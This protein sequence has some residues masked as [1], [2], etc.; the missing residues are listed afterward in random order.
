MQQP[1]APYQYLISFLWSLFEATFFFIIPDVWLSFASLESLKNGFKNIGFA[2]LGAL[3]GGSIMY[4]LGSYTI[5]NVATFLEFIPDIN[6]NRLLE[7]EEILKNEGLTAIF[8][9][10]IKGIPYKIYAS[11][12]GVLALNFPL[13]ILISIPARAMRFIITVV[14]THLVSKIILKKV[15]L[16]NKKIILILIWILLYTLYFTSL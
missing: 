5:I 8:M 1:K 6:S 2:L 12:S 16:S 13:F 15:S 14:I 11:Y 7:V 10:P 3:V 4:V 9:G